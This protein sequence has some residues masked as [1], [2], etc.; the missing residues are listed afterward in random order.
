MS[1]QFPSRFW[2]SLFARQLTILILLFSVSVGNFV[3]YVTAEKRIDLANQLRFESYVLVDELRQSSDD[4]T[5]MVRTYIE[6]GNSLYKQHYQE[7]INIRDGLEF[8]PELYEYSYWDLVSENNVRP[9]PSSGKKMALMA[10][11]ADTGVSNEVWQ[12]LLDA[13]KNSDVLVESERLAMQ[14]REFEG[15][16]AEAKLQSARQLI[17]SPAYR[18]AK[19]NIMRPIATAQRLIDIHTN[20]EIKHATKVAAIFRGF[21]VLFIIAL[22]YSMWRTYRALRGTLG[23]SVDEVKSKIERIANGDFVA[24]SNDNLKHQDTVVGWLAVMQKKLMDSNRQQQQLTQRLATEKELAQVTLS[25]IGDAVITTDA[26]GSVTLMN[27]VAIKLTGWTMADALGKPLPAVFKIINE[28]TRPHIENPVDKVLRG[29]ASE[30]L[31]NH[32]VLI[33]HDRKEYNIEDSAAPILLESGELIGCVLVFHDVTEKHRLL[34][35]VRWQAGHDVL[36]GLPNRALLADRFDR[37]LLHA[38]RHEERLVVCLLDL[39][40]FKPVNDLH[41]HVVGDQLLVEAAQRLTA[42]L[43]AE[44]TVARMGG[45]E[46]VMLL[47]GVQSQDEAY[48]TLQR[49]IEAMV[50]PYHIDG[51][52]IMVSASIGA[53]VFPDDDADSDTLLRHA[54]QAMYAAKQ[55]GRNRFHFF[56]VLQDNEIQNT[57]QQI[58]DLSAALAKHELRLHYQPK[59][60]MRSGAVA[61][62]EAL[63]RWQHPQRGLLLP[64][65][66]LRVAEDTDLIVAIGE[67]VVEQALLQIVVWLEQGKDWLVSVNISA[68]H[69]REPDFAERLKVLL[70]RHSDA[71]PQYL[72][73]EILESVAVKNLEQVRQTI[74]QCQALG[75]SF[76][77]DDFG[78]GYSSLSYL[79]HL[80]VEVLKIDQSFV[81]D[82]LDD[83]EDLALVEAIISLAR[84]FECKVIAEGVESIEHGT[85]LMRL[86]C[87]VVQGYAVARPMPAGELVGWSKHFQ[88]APEWMMWT[89]VQWPLQDIPLMV[90]AHE[91]INWVDNIAAALDDP[92]AHIDTEQLLNHHGCRFG[93]WYDGEGSARYAH[94]PEFTQVQA[95]HMQVHRLGVEVILM[96]DAGDMVA[97]RGLLSELQAC[98]DT[99]LSELSL[100]QVALSQAQRGGK[101]S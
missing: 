77:L 7:I 15:A 44:D 29:E 89:D 82:I 4:L 86:G 94:L 42:L 9:T 23:G 25:S 85:L 5:S 3:L 43:R 30:L 45:D 14:M 40:D 24:S 12:L 57:H 48:Q 17:Y 21:M 56:D 28:A 99:I 63:L 98:K 1:V 31:A 50:E 64:G 46:F 2:G 67:W 11:I 36:T 76:A 92:E 51:N 96:R 54:D 95:V 59:V 69:F 74:L 55:S 65:E 58:E 6:T 47:G 90:A 35:D 97:A 81:R 71:P 101:N 19:A 49:V 52:T 61:G 32:T 72:R 16:D 62:V 34:S 37:A 91:H 73:I 18:L 100:L 88:L 39:D 27:Q 38:Q 84:V 33:A 10:E 80:P 8:D 87:D 83:K 53:V 78:T 79:K 93:E 22:M 26:Q 66:F 20:E 60:N 13:K 75:V 68:R 70:G 41:G